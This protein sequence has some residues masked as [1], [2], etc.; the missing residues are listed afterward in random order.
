MRKPLSSSQIVCVI[1][2]WCV[3][4]YLVIAHA[5]RIDGMVVVSILFSAALVFI[6]VYRSIKSRRR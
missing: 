1:L 4:C 5:R 3:L 6:P 2:L